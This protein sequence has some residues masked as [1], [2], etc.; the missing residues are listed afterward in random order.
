MSPDED[1]KKVVI[2]GGPGHPTLPAESLI[3]LTLNFGP[4]PA[5]PPDHLR[6]IHWLWRLGAIPVWKKNQARLVIR[7]M[8]PEQ[9]ERIEQILRKE[10]IPFEVEQ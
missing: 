1:E 5:L 3:S 9:Y 10:Q 2:C 7:R 8:R 6:T 4:K